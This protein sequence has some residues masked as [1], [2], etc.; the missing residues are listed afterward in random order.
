MAHTSVK[1]SIALF[2]A[3]VLAFPSAAGAAN[4]SKIILQDGT[5]YEDVAFLVESAYKV[6]T[7]TKDDWERTVSFTD[8]AYIYNSKG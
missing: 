4:A 3:F 6:V 2:V 1:I 8:I 7:I 5:V